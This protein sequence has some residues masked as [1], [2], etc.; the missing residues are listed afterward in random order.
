[1]KYLFKA[2]IPFLLLSVLSYLIYK[3]YDQNW[4]GFEGYT[5]NKGEFV[6]PKKL[7]DWLQLLIVPILLAIGAWW[8]NKSQ[9]KSEQHIET[10][11]QRQK[12]LEDYFNCMTD[13][14]LEKN[15]RD[16]RNNQEA[17]AIARTRTLAVLRILDGS[18]KGQAIQFLYE[19]DLINKNPKVQL[20]GADLTDASL[21]GA[22]LRGA[23]LR[24]L[25]FN[26]AHFK[27]ANMEGADLRGSDFSCADFSDAK[28]TNAN[29]TQAILKKAKLRNAD[30]TNVNLEYADLTQADLKG[31]KRSKPK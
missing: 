3:G 21:N 8:L 11:R 16:S 23:E 31:A 7:W 5:N 13:L 24:G 30:L 1:M 15:L 12:A 29:L 2:I 14:L 22:V 27:A 28:M 6:P 19:L 25:Y 9:K 4:T 10:D 26:N 20:N 17:P 18:R